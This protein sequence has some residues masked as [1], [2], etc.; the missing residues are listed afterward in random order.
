MSLLVYV[1]DVDEDLSGIFW[2]TQ[3]TNSNNID[4]RRLSALCCRHGMVIVNG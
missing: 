3:E 2:N 1:C 4:N